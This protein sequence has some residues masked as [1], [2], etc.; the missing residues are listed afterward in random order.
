MLL[1]EGFILTAITYISA[2]LIAIG[3]IIGIFWPRPP[4]GSMVRRW[5]QLRYFSFVRFRMGWRGQDRYPKKGNVTAMF[6]K[7]VLCTILREI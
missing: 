3:D 2:S 1:L 6:K 4:T 7:H 5:E